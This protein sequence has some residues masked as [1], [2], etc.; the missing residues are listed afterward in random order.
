MTANAAR[1]L[2][3]SLALHAGLLAYWNYGTAPH[4]AGLRPL[5]LTLN[6][7]GAA[8]AGAAVAPATAPVS[9][10]GTAINTAA[11][12]SHPATPAPDAPDAA[13]IAPL[14]IA[15]NN[16]AQTPA[17]ATAITAAPPHAINPIA[18]TA[19]GMDAAAPSEAEHTAAAHDPA[20]VQ[21]Y[22][23]TRLRD[24]VA[25][26][27]SYPLLAKRRGWE[28]NVAVGLRVEH[29]GR[30]SGIHLISSSGY[31]IIDRDALRVLRQLPRLDGL[32]G[33]LENGHFDMV[34]PIEYYLTD[35]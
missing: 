4:P 18:A 1:F 3:L 21:R 35:G 12:A 26:Y 7:G 14:P 5:L 19:A 23:L 34:L 25:P 22:L 16:T 20:S 11:S 31:G 6:S 33:W 8:A 24:A 9:N 2:A 30:L 15:V 13:S 29:D 32:A 10:P 17:A 28:G 27:F